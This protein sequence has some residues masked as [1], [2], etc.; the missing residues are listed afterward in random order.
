MHAR[1]LQ[2]RELFD[3]DPPAPE[4][5]LPRQVR[6]EALELLTQWLYTLSKAMVEEGGDEQD[7]R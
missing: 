7:Q 1:K 5:V 2:Q 4:R 6:D 3:D